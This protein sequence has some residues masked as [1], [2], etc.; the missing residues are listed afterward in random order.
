VVNSYNIQPINDWKDLNSKFVLQV[1]RGYLLCADKAFLWD[2]WESIQVAMEHVARFDYDSDG[3]VENEGFPDQ[4]YDTWSALGCSAYSGGLWLAALSAATS[5]SHILGLPEWTDKYLSIYKRGRANYYAKLWNGKY[6]NYDSS[7]NPQHDSIMADQMCGQWYARSCGLPPIASPPSILSALRTIYESNVMGFRKGVLGAVN[8][9]RPNG[10]VDTDSLQSV[11]VWTGTTYGVAATMLG[12]GLIEE[13]FDT[14][15][16]IVNTTYET[17]GYQFQT[18]EAWNSTGQY[19]AL[20]YM[21]PLA[22][23]GMQWVW[24]REKVRNRKKWK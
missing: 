19:R 14:A 16:G 8:G 10:N 18:P 23:W 5:I 1:Y 11:E 7:A 2:C 3:V 6:F 17:K 13:G 4:T 21:R 9:M 12:E 22:I 20:S 15:W 24:E